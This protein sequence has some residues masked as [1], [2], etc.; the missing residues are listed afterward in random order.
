MNGDAVKKSPC[1]KANGTVLG[2]EHPFTMFN[3]DGEE[4]TTLIGR[5][6]IERIP[7]NAFLPIGFFMIAA[8]VPAVL[9][10]TKNASR[11]PDRVLLQTQD[12]NC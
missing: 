9:V 5:S 11:Q 1:C 8:S 6:K 10:N 2:L 12:K 3:K 7:K 4:K